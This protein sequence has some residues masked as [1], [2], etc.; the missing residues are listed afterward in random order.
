MDS[1]T[2]M[3]STVA[4]IALAGFLLPWIRLDGHNDPMT[5]S[6]II[7][8]AF[9]SPERATIFSTSLPSSMALLMIPPVTAIAV[10]YGMVRL[11]QGGHSLGSHLLGAALPLVMVL[12]TGAIAS[13]DGFRIGGIPLPGIGIIATVITQG[14]LFL[15]A[16]VEGRE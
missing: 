9:T 5:G 11:I 7:A 4:L 8:Y 13:S 15:D 2:I 6:E 12:S 14:I 1:Q 16:L 3:R 10:L